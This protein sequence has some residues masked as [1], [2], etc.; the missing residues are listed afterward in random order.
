[1]DVAKF[2]LV[3]HPAE[4]GPGADVVPA[5]IAGDHRHVSAPFQNPNVDRDRLSDTCKKLRCLGVPAETECL[6]QLG[7]ML[8][9]LGQEVT[10][11]PDEDPGIPEITLRA[12]L[13]RTRP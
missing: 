6:C 8:L 12:Q 9:N 13:L 1:S 2:V 7:C 11:T 5:E 10:D 3:A 4:R